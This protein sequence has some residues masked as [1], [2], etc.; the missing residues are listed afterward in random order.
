MMI[1][2]IKIFSKIQKKIRRFVV[3]KKKIMR[4][5][6]PDC[7][8]ESLT[9]LFIKLLF[10]YSVMNPNYTEQTTTIILNSTA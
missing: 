9:V 2:I 1:S 5:S 10:N 8:I 4:G 6:I 7:E 3:R